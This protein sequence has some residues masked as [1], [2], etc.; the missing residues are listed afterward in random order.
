MKLFQRPLALFTAA[1]IAGIICIVQ[2]HI[3]P[4]IGFGVA[5]ALYI[6][7]CFIPAG[8]GQRILLMLVVGVFAVGLVRTM[9]YRH[10]LYNDLSRYAKGKM[11]YVQGTVDSA[12][13]V[14]KNGCRFVIKASMV[15]AYNREYAVTG[16]AMV[17]LYR[18]FHSN[19][20]VQAPSYG[21]KVRIRGRL[22][23]PEEGSG[24]G[25]NYKA[26]LARQRVFS[27]IAAVV[28]NCYTEPS[29][30]W[31]I[32]SVAEGFR[33]S[34]KKQ[35][36]SLFSPLHAEMLLGILLGSYSALPLDIQNAFMR[37]GTMHLLAA[38]GFNCSILLAIFG[39]ALRRLSTPKIAVNILLIGVV[40]AFTIM[41]GAG[42]SI[43]RAAVMVTAYLSA[44]LF[45]RSAD[46]L[47]TVLIAALAILAIN[48]L[49]LYDVGFQLS[50]M[51]VLSI[52]LIVPVLQHHVLDWLS[53]ERFDERIG[54]IPV[55][56][57]IMR[58]AQCIVG[59]V[60][61]S[62]VAGLGTWP[63][64]ATYFNYIS[65]V[66]PIANALT[67]ILVILL[68][69]TGIIS[70]AVSAYIPAAGQAL[71]APAAFIMNCMTGVVTS[72]GGHHWSI[73]AVKSPPAFTVVAYF[74]ILI[75]V[76]EF[77]YRKTAPK[78]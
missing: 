29:P 45:W 62:I 52:I 41:A 51:A 40:W 64:T 2:L 18:P 53:P 68:T 37:S 6:A 27:E 30:K 26:Y 7:A 70:M 14:I 17:T 43:V 20:P 28:G 9:V 69:I 34:L 54:G 3:S 71:A 56:Y 75:G 16:R 23:L 78:S 50:F 55:V 12:P 74:I 13:V 8:S 1:Y 77:A 10:V 38:S 4:V 48:P 42:P 49:Q 5:M 11:V 58:T 36:Y 15:E 59:A 25:V 24:S 47:N 76:L 65:L 57:I 66:S 32:G 73:T 67:A 60:M 33:S 39:Y 22:Q 61:L 44:Y 46:S 35:A 72:L 63:L 19:T 21:A 31:S